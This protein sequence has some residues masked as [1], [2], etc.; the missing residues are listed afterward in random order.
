MHGPAFTKDR[1]FK[2]SI[3]AMTLLLAFNGR[4]TKTMTTPEEEGGERCVCLGVG[5]A[6]RVL[7]NALHARDLISVV[8]RAAELVQEDGEHL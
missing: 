4:I 8:E 1:P 2:P 7:H 5:G 6:N 3:F